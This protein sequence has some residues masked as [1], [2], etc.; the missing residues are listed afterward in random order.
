V[1]AERLMAALVAAYPDFLSRYD[2]NDIVWKDGTRMAFDTAGRQGLRD[3]RRAGPGG[4]VLCGLPAGHTSATPAFNSD[5]GRV[6][7][8]CSPR[9]MATAARARARHLVDVVWLPSKGGQKLKAS[10]INGVA[11]RL[12][13]VSD[14]LDKLPAD[15]TK[16]L[17]P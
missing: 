11:E 17:V 16:Y 6:I 1:R 15:M 8:R 5:P 3:P 9:C 12:Q 2:G 4:H 14:E 7:S 13:A 10:R